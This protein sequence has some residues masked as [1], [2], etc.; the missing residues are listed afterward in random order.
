[1]GVFFCRISGSILSWF[2]SRC[3]T[4]INAIPED[5]GIAFSSRLNASSPPAEAPTPTTGNP[6]DERYPELCFSLD[7]AMT[8]E[9]FRKLRFI[10]GSSD[11]VSK[12]V[13]VLAGAYGGK[14][15]D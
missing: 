15:D 8:A 14:E 4:R 13:D 6:S 9:V 12:G 2:G 7:L 1:M 3:C 11:S 10:W 5:S